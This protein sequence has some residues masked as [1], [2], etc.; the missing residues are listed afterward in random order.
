MRK[1]VSILTCCDADPDRERFGAPALKGSE[2]ALRWDG[3]LHGLPRLIKASLDCRD[4]EGRSPRFTWLLR[5]DHQVAKLMGQA[6]A[7]YLQFRHFWD[8]RANLGDELGWHP[9]HWRLIGSEALWQQELKDNVWMAEH[10]REAHRALARH[11]KLNTVKTGW[12]FMNTTTLETFQQLG[13][14]FE[15]SAM[16]GQFYQPTAEVGRAYYGEYNWKNTGFTAYYPQ[17]KDYQLAMEPQICGDNAPLLEIPISAGSDAF[18]T[19]LENWTLAL[20]RR[21]WPSPRPGQFAT[22]LKITFNPWLFRRLWRGFLPQLQAQREPLIHTYF[23]PDETL[24]LRGR[25]AWFY[26]ALNARNNLNFVLQSCRELGWPTRF[27]TAQEY[28]ERF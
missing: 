20:R 25:A 1:T 19:L 13:L 12:C 28:G 16:P 17:A 3:V 6:D 21:Q 27:V 22:S 26:S 2:V 11:L 18:V 15:V 23:H 7:A 4:A 14:K 9:H 10:L 24:P 5:A 8:D